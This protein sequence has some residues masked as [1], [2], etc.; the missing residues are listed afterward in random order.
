MKIILLSGGSGKRLWPLSNSSRAKQYLSVL[1]GPDGKIESMLQRLWRQLDEADLQEHTRIATCRG[2]LEILQ[3]QLGLEAPV[4]IESEQRDTYP[5]IALASAYLYSIAGV[6]LSETVIVMPVD[7]YVDSEFFTFIRGIPKLVR[8]S[9][10]ELL[11]VGTRPCCPSEQY[12]YII[13]DACRH[14]REDLYEQTVK[15]FKEKPYE[16]EA[17]SLMKEGALWN[18]GIY[19][20]QLDFMI[21]LL[22]NRGLPI[23]YD[24]LYKQYYRLPKTSFETEVTQKTTMR[25]VIRYE[26]CW[27]DLGTWKTLSQEIAFERMGAGVISSDSEQSQLFNELD[28]P[29]SIIGLNNIFVAASPDGILVASKSADSMLNAK[30]QTMNERPKYEER[31]WGHSKVVDSAVLASGLH[32]VTKRLFI[33]AGHNTSYQMHFRRKEAWTV[34]SGEGILILDE[35][36]R[37]IAPGDTVTIPERARHSVRATV[38]MELI[39]VQ[40][41]EQVTDDDIIRLGVTWDE[42]TSQINMV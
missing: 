10:S 5:A 11:M 17:E 41:G 31:R 27:K 30:L 35:M 9:R 7:A 26:G 20:F 23:H 6:S 1:E 4:I 28:I 42:I 32:S 25:S 12:G 21:T 40:T 36:Y 22:M 38:N 33:A 2:Q 8:E 3:R 16:R 18:T 29:I 19:A 14:S 15:K 34:L 24:E 39:E 37:H 13:P